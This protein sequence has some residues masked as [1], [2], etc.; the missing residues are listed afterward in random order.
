MTFCNVT[1]VDNKMAVQ[2]YTWITHLFD[3]RFQNKCVP[4][5]YEDLL[6]LM[7]RDK[8]EEPLWSPGES[9][10]RT[11]WPKNLIFISE[12]TGAEMFPGHDL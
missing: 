10:F 12:H 2:E 5:T 9:I 7:I 11:K 6:E 8:F 4:L 1:I 3:E